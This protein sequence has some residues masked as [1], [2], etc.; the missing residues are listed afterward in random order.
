MNITQTENTLVLSSTET[1]DFRYLHVIQQLTLTATTRI[2]EAFTNNSSSKTLPS[3]G[4]YKI[5]EIMMPS[6]PGNY[7]YIVG[8]VIYDPNGDPVTIDEVLA[9]DPEDNG[10]DRN[11]TDFFTVY[12]LNT[13]YINLLK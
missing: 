13:Y 9:L 10:I 12:A 3:D 6:V 5:T 11:D 8:N 2:H 4:Y 1:T 7:Y